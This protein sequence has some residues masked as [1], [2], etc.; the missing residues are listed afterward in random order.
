V[1]QIELGSTLAEKGDF[2]TALSHYLRATELAPS[3]PGF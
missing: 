2:K 1:I 3:E